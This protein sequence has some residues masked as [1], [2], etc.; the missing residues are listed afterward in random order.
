MVWETRA[1]RFFVDCEF[2]D[3]APVVTLVSVAAVG[4][5]GSEYYAVSSDF[6]PL[7]V[8]PWVAEHVLPQLPPTSTWKPRAVIARELEEF[9]GEDPVWWAGVGAHHHRGDF[10]L[11]G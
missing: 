2:G 3:T 1:V 9:F 7:A 6:D 11:W 8:H 10:P 4:E 5:D